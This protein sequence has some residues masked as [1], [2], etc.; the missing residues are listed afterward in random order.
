M[1]KGEGVQSRRSRRMRMG[2]TERS[3]DHLDL[4]RRAKPVLNTADQSDSASIFHQRPSRS[5]GSSMP[6]SHHPYRN[7]SQSPSRARNRPTLKI[8]DSSEL[9]S[10][11]APPY[12]VA[13]FIELTVLP[14]SPLSS[15]ILFF[16]VKPPSATPPFAERL[17]HP[18]PPAKRQINLTRIN[19]PS[20]T[21]P[22]RI[23]LMAR[24]RPS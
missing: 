11:I 8:P 4:P 19:L 12:A 20:Q 2:A 21:R 16:N 9:S 3:V 14:N 18:L 22:S 7:Q 15:R 1:G 24:L 6:S 23:P 5:R 10:S 13:F 17:P